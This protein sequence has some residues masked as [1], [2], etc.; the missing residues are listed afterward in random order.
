MSLCT[1]YFNSQLYSRQLYITY[2]RLLKVSM[3]S[4]CEAVK[5]LLVHIIYR[6][7]QD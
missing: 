6:A 7:L 2:G 3:K 4:E 5:I 1:S